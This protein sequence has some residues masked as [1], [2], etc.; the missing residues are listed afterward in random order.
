MWHKEISKSLQNQF[1]SNSISEIQ[2]TF[3][4]ISNLRHLVMQSINSEIVL[5]NIFD[6]YGLKK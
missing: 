5:H 6:E 4:Q 1:L 2:R 3:K